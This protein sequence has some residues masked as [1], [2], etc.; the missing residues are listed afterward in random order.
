MRFGSASR[1]RAANT[2]SKVHSEAGTSLSGHWLLVARVGWIALVALATG[3]FI[4]SLPPYAAQMYAVSN[5]L[6]YVPWQ[7]SPESSQALQHIGISL[8]VYAPFAIALS[9]TIALVW[10]V[11]GVVIFWRKSD[12][13]MAL[14][15]AFVLV[16][17]GASD[18]TVISHPNNVFWALA[19][20][21]LNFFFATASLLFFSI[22]PNGRFVPIWTR[23]LVI[24]SIA[25]FGVQ[26]FFPD[27]PLNPQNWPAL[28]SSL[29]LFGVF[30]SLTGAQIYRY[31][32]VFSPVQRQQTKWVVY[33]LA[34]VVLGIVVDVVVE[35]LL[36]LH[37]PIFL[38]Q[39]LGPVAW[40][41]VPVLIPISLGIAILRYRLWDI[42]III[43][44]T[45]MYGILTVS[46]VA[47]YML[48]VLGLGTLFQAQGNLIIALLATGL[49][50]VL[51][52]PLRSRLQ[53]AVNRLMYGERDDPYR[54][55]TRLGR[56]LEA[57]LAPEA[58]LPTI[59][60]TVA[61]ALRLPYVAITLREGDTSTPAASFGAPRQG[62]GLVR[63]PLVAQHERV[64]ELVL[65]PRAP[66]E[67]FTSP[68]QRLLEDLTRQIGVAVY[69]VRLTADLKRLTIDL[70]RSRERLVTA[71]EE[72][73]RRL[74]RD[75]HD[76]LGPQL[77]SLTLKLETARNR[78]A[79]DPLADTLLSDLTARTQATVADI[80]RLVYA[81]RPPALDELGL[82]PALREQ[83]LQYGDQVSVHLDAPECLPELT[84]AV[85]VAV[86]RITQEAL[87]NVARHAHAHHCDIQLALD[88]TAGLLTLSIQDD[89][90]GLP[91][92]RGVGVGLTS[93]RERAEEL[94]GTWSIEQVLTGGTCVLAR[95]PYARTERA[96]TVAV[97]T[98]Q[99]PHQEEE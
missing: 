47:L 99:V 41:L 70:Q 95:L 21:G 58:M 2:E 9:S 20:Q 22:F 85:E 34:L 87:T 60:E 37:L 68:D 89:G 49:I 78:L 14:L 46:I 74:R 93:M 50:A 13:W 28:S 81:L 82:I 11:V 97:T 30:G 94:G 15:I 51:F 92:S 67:A 69:A 38:T 56:R 65:A 54:V 75:L 39:F 43:N 32:R 62:E 29:F 35:D 44:R 26:Y 88:E 18:I 52:H 12:D 4:V 17:G 3:D 59:V 80:R 45:L 23:W 64:G 8:A 90:H 36:Q 6:L 53:R 98:S 91:P 76:G 42:D 73:R 83:A 31:R 77:A 86:Y 25:L 61:L 84:A 5:D 16:Q 72:E 48:V 71:R 79:H 96:D 55:L 7:L 40:S 57:T 63:L 33:A 66:G 10:I 27:S 1:Q 24:V 19:L